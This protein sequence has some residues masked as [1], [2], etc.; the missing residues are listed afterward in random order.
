MIAFVAEITL[1]GFRHPEGL[2]AELLKTL[3][4]SSATPQTSS[5]QALRIGGIG[6]AKENADLATLLAA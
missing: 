4:E 1:Y 5:S 6:L 2:L 3:E